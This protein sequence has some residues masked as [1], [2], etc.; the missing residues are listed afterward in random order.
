MGGNTHL[1][2]IV[3]QSAM[4][5]PLLAS[6]LVDNFVTGGKIP[7]AAV[8]PIADRVGSAWLAFGK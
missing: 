6:P 3:G 8:D 7:G 1:Q 5:L 2:S 4:V